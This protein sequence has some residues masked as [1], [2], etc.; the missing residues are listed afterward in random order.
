MDDQFGVITGKPI[1][2]GG[3]AGR[4]DATARGGWYV[5]R[6]AAKELGIDLRGATVAIQG[7]G[8]AG[9]YA[10]KLGQSLH[11]CKV[12]AVSDSRGAIYSENGLEPTEVARHK[13]DT[14]SVVGYR[15]SEPISNS[16]LLELEVDI[17][18]PSALENVITADNAPKVKAKIVGELAN[19]P[20]TPDA[21][22]VLYENGVHVLPDFLC[23]AGG[24]TVSYFEMVQNAYMHYWDGP[25]S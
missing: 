17:L 4:G 23:N 25:R 15:D 2:L 12:V 24:V 11:G 5:I 19:G 7:F 10:A 20:T 9:C 6:E 16:E 13:A 1:V 8:N 18:V 3:S 22:D 21:D 14:G